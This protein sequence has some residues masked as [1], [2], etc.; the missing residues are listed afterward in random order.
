MKKKKYFEN[1]DERFTNICKCNVKKQ[2]SILDNT[3]KI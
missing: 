1:T 3:K 2:G